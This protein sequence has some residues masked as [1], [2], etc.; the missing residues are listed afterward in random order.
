MST[1]THTHSHTRPHNRVRHNI[2]LA[3]NSR[4]LMEATA[5][6]VNDKV[7]EARNR[8]AAALKRSAELAANVRDKAAAG[9]KA[10]DKAIRENP[11]KALAIAVGVGILIGLV[12]ARRPSQTAKI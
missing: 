9:A 10:T 5:G 3:H 6:I 2:T 4:D 8:V 1:H 11:Y 7:E 12:K